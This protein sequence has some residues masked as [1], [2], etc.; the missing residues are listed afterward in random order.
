M[1]G[2]GLV[3]AGNW[4]SNWLR[5]LAT[6]PEASLRWCC[7]L[8]PTL[9]DQIAAQH[10]SVRTTPQ[11]DDLLADPETVGIV[12]AS[13]VPTHFVLAKKALQAGKHVMVEKPMALK[14][15]EAIELTQLAKTQ[16][17]I[18]MVGHLME[19][20]SAIPSLRRLID[21]GELGEVRRIESR[22]SNHGVLRTDE[23]AW[24]SL[25]PHDISMVIRLMGDWPRTVQCEGQCIVQPN[26]ADV[27]GGTLR[28]SG[29]R[30]AR[31]DASWHD[32]EKVRQIKIYGTRKWAVFNDM[33]PWERKLLVYDRGF[34]VEPL[35]N[36][37]RMIT[38]R[39]GGEQA[40]VLDTTEPLIAEARHFLECIRTG[41]QPLSDG[42]S[43]T[44]VVSVLE[45]GQQ[46]IEAIREVPVP[47]PPAGFGLRI[48]G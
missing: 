19:Y 37:K 30:V 21:C 16:D 8:N 29:G 31:I 36:G 25:A 26:V 3:G 32:P 46:S 34:D 1:T 9:L 10:P 41:Q 12:I 14:A 13:I 44:A 22:R 38:A 47:S 48:A 24:W 23:N 4:G 28:F 40:I 42:I 33:V 17:R 27:V 45:A 2:V 7:D 6:M 43:G 5:T 18:L 39:R 35:S 20:H 11:F 15:K